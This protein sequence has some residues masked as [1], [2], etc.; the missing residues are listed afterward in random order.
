MRLIGVE[1]ERTEAAALL[2][3]IEKLRCGSPDKLKPSETNPNLLDEGK[4]AKVSTDYSSLGDTFSEVFEAVG[5]ILSERMGD[6][7]I[8]T[9]L[10]KVNN[11]LQDAKDSIADFTLADVDTSRVPVVERDLRDIWD[12]VKE[13][14]RHVRILKNKHKEQLTPTDLTKMDTEV[15]TLFS[16]A[17]AHA[18]LIRKKAQDLVPPMS[19]FERA[20]LAQQ[21]QVLELQEQTLREQRAY[22]SRTN[23]DRKSEAIARMNVS[24]E[25]VVAACSQLVSDVQAGED[26]DD[27]TSVDDDE[28][29]KAMRAKPNWE[30]RMADVQEEYMRYKTLVATFLP[31]SMSDDESSFRQLTDHFELAKTTLED[32]VEAIEEEDAKRNLYT[33]EKEPSSKLEYPKFSGKFSEC[34]LKFR[35]KMERAFKANRVPVVDQVDKLRDQLSGFALSL[36]PDSMKDIKVAFQALH[37]Q[38]G[39]PERVLDNRLKDLKKLGQLPGKDG[40]QENYQKQVQWYLTLDGLLQDLIELGDRG[41]DLAD[42][43]FKQSTVRDILNLFPS[44]LHLKLS[45]LPGRKREKLVNIKDQLQSFRNDAQLL[46][47]ERKGESGGRA[48]GGGGSRGTAGGGLPGGGGVSR[49]QAHPIYKQPQRD[50]TCRVCGVLETEGETGLYDG[51]LS[52]WPTGCPKFIEMTAAER[53]V[54][55]VKA[56]LCKSCLSPEVVFTPQHIDECKIRKKAK[57]KDKS[58]F[59]CTFKKCA[60][61]LWVCKFHKLEN[62]AMMKKTK[63]ELQ[64]KGLTLAHPT[65]KLNPTGKSSDGKS[66]SSAGKNLGG[67]LISPT[68]KNGGN[69]SSASKGMEAASQDKDDTRSEEKGKLRKFFNSAK[70][71]GMEVVGEPKGR[72]IFLFFAVKGRN[73][74][75]QTFFDNGCS[76]CVVREGIPGVEWKGIITKRGPFGIGGVGGLSS[77]TKDEW[78]VLVPRA[79]GKMQAVRCHSMNQVTC[80]FPMYDLTDA[81]RAVKEDAP[82]SELLQNCKLP[83]IIGGE[84]DCLLG[85]KYSMMH[86]EPIHT[87][88]ESGLS[89]YSSKLMSH[90]G[91]TNAMIGGSHESFE[92]F[93]NIAGGVSQLMAH[94][95]EGLQQFRKGAV[96]RIECNPITFEEAEHAKRSNLEFCEF[97]GIV[98]LEELIGEEGFFEEYAQEGLH[99]EAVDC[100]CCGEEMRMSELKIIANE[101][102]P[103]KSARPSQE[104]AMVN[105]EE[106]IADIKRWREVMDSGMNIDYRCVKC[107]SCSDC[108]NADETEK[109]S[110]R[111]DAEDQLIRESVQLD[112]A[113]K[114]IMATLPLRGKEEDFLSSNRERAMCVLD[115]QCR[116]F[117]GKQEDINLIKKA[118][119]KLFDRGYMVL[120]K[121]IPADKR[122][123]FEEKAVQH[124][125]PWRV[126]YNPKSKS[127]PVRPVMDASSRTPT[128]QDGRGGRCLNDLVCKGRIETLNLV[129]LVL[130]F[131]MGRYAL[132]GDLSQFYN[133]LRL[134]E[135]FWN[136]QRFLWRE[137]LE[138]KEEVLEAIIVTLIYGVKSVSAQSETAMVKLARDIKEKCPALTELLLTGRYVDDMADSKATKQEILELIRMADEVFETVGISCK[139]WTING[140]DPPEEVSGGDQ[141]IGVAGLL[142]AP[143][144]DVVMVNI[145]PL[146]FGSVRRGRLEENTIQ[147]SGDFGNLEKFVPGKL[148]LRQVLSK[149]AS[150]FDIMGF[151]APII[152]GL[153]LDIRK[154]AKVVTGWDG[155][156]PAEWRTKWVKNFWIL[157]QLRGMG[158]NRAIMPKDAANTRARAIVLVDAALEVVMLGVWIGFALL[159]GGWSCQLLIG[160]S[161]LTDENSTIPKNELQALTSGSNLGWTVMKALEGWI[162]EKI[163]GSD[164]TIALSWT[165]AEMKPLAMYHKNRVIQIRRGTDLEE[166]YH[167]RTEANCSDVGTRPGKVSL[168]EVGPGS[169]WQEGHPW[170]RLDVD[171]AVEQGYIKPASK[172]RMTAEEEHD[173]DRGLVY[174]KIPE[175][176]TKGHVVSTKRVDLMEER[177]A[178]ATYLLLPTKFS[179]PKTVRVYSVV[180]SFIS[181]CRR[182][183]VILSRLLCEG[184]LVFRMF[185]A[186]L[187]DKETGLELSSIAMVTSM[188][189]EEQSSKCQSLVSQFN[190][191][192]FMSDEQR[193][194]FAATQAVNNGN[195]VTET[196]KYTNMALLYLFRKATEEVKEFNSSAVIQKIGIE[197][198]GVLLSSGRII[199]EMEF[200]ESG[201]IDVDLGA[202][203]IRTRVP[204]LDRYSPLAY[205]IAQYIHWDLA[206]HRGAETC[207]R[208]S[209]E[210][211]SIMQGSALYREIGH[212][213]PRCAIKRKR[214]LEAAIGPIRENQLA[215]APPFWFCQMDLMGPVDV[216]APGFERETRGRKVKQ[217]KC[218]I[219]VSVCPTTKLTNLQVVESSS[220]SGIMSGI[221]R[222]GCEVG[223]PSKM[224]IDQDRASM[225]GFKSVEFD[226][227]NLQLTLERKYGL[228]FEVCP[229]QGHNM[230]GQ[231]ERVI[232]SV[233]ESFEDAGL[234]A[235]RYHATGLQTLCKVVENQYNNL[236]LGYHFGRD[237]DNGPLLK[238]ICPNHLRVGRMNKRALDGPARLPKNKMEM[239]KVVDETYKTWF[240][241]WRDSYVPKLMFKPKWFRTDRDLLVGDLVYFVKKDGGLENKWTMGMVETVEKGRDGV[242]R[243]AVIKYCN[244]SEQKLSLDKNQI[245]DDSTFPRYTERAVRKLIKIF[246]LEET[247]VAD[248]LAELDRRE[249]QYHGRGQGMSAEVT[250]SMLGDQLPRSLFWN[251]CKVCCC[252]EHC[253]YSLHLSAK[254]KQKVLPMAVDTKGMY[255]DTLMALEEEQASG[256][257]GLMG[258]VFDSLHL[259][260]STVLGQ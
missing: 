164:S 165:M 54:V 249:K 176:L 20:S 180:F 113:K 39:D 73:K 147:F 190:K 229:V 94:F 16:E 219:M 170:M 53:F 140:E 128:R 122:K 158:F 171:E 127:T 90:D 188:R 24:Y 216:F 48:V 239:L 66:I 60:T 104:Q 156:M 259:D 166:L 77:Q 102:L 97:G 238:M 246:S 29:R 30:K 27:W 68:G 174:E 25:K 231:V 116:K 222:L 191:E 206:M 28:I 44:K 209:M 244:A 227:R 221:I 92:F 69:A 31:E 210:H 37:D 63:E 131:V 111:Q 145:P 254:V 253:G 205:S 85:I 144:I 139:G 32:A 81:V 193:K 233:Q 151:L 203:G 225:C 181:K 250:S 136:L 33:Q 215:I 141:V 247:S 121:D 230:H 13:F 98:N 199:S 26:D 112:Y 56:K 108:R 43:A 183:R 162:M 114:E 45:K 187:E 148:T 153:R 243:K 6:P 160:R 200:L 65:L 11:I 125:I 189:G 213:C 142:W 228:E 124:Y 55:V 109:V 35:E 236:P 197:V 178:H 14:R 179:F 232:R 83:G 223:V 50:E 34:F 224:F 257:M 152:G 194:M 23:D 198:D 143:K 51:H 75:V 101:E 9:D 157:E 252:Q 19:E 52:S 72:P 218:W 8:R 204:I 42:E 107:R 2:S 235:G 240:R 155:E 40:G 196:D 100:I 234:F 95:T 105:S 186:K 132:T 172:L 84:V 118:F 161:G 214:F 201:E 138:L 10:E 149:T 67:S 91:V 120:L 211:V 242:I 61:H 192:V 260:V 87:L 134:R 220:A 49:G 135:E 5:N 255:L 12:Q 137:N 169:V 64:K 154:T 173:Y 78:M 1:R 217:S 163:V 117:Q 4:M 110:L 59:S 103:I 248:D 93:A 175:V 96:P 241:I 168:Q 3:G 126:V 17:K 195:E 237:Q 123:M 99:R 212:N 46:D 21:R 86:P 22:Q 167:V 62:A 74:P 258:G 245:Q 7:E 47:K 184:Q 119:G 89:I 18:K 130:K 256:E 115:Q 70:K 133:C 36:V 41:E 80:N 79:D 38:W 82:N 129:R 182:G 251:Q 57:E 150:V 159:G 71:Q 185:N 76:D 106:R 146:H 88:V 226:L 15:E 207:S 58:S 208:I 202:L 177:A